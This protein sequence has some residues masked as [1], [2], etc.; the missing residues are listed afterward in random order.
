MANNVQLI[1]EAI[2]E[3]N[4]IG[5][6]EL[7]IEV[8]QAWSQGNLLTYAEWKKK[9]F[10]VQKGQK[11]KFSCKLWKKKTKAELEKEKKK[12][13]DEAKAKGEK[14]K[15]PSQFVMTKCSFFLP[16]QVEYIQNEVAI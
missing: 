12:L 6:V 11:A 9:G 13:E 8:T 3:L 4:L 16:S 14:P 1:G 15:K 10:Q 5:E 7:A 2:E